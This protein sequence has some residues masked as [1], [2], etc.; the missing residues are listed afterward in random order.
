MH[1]SEISNACKVNIP[2]INEFAVVARMM[3]CGAC[4]IYNM[5]ID[6]IEDLKIASDEAICCLIN[7]PGMASSIDITAENTNAGI[8]VEFMA[9]SASLTQ[10][11][12]KSDVDITQAILETLIPKVNIC[13][14]DRGVFCITFFFPN[15]EE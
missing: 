15:N 13:S 14:D 12:E 9:L 11:R 3:L 2:A 6:V 10:S 1:N 5:D 8:I 4:A 7:Q